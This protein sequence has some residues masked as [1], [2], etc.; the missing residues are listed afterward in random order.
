MTTYLKPKYISFDCHGTLINFQTA[1]YKPRLRAFEYMIGQLDCNPEDTLHVSA[2]MRYDH[3]SADGM[4]IKNK[5]FVNRGHE[6][7]WPAWG[8]HEVRDLSGLPAL[9]GL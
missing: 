1:A 3:L 5:V 4:G 9:A 8:S 6:P 7:A 2:S